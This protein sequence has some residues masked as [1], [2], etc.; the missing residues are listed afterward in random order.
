MSGISVDNLLLNDE[1]IK[2][3][4]N[5][6]RNNAFEY[7]GKLVSIGMIPKFKYEN[8]NAIKIPEYFFIIKPSKC[9]RIFISLNQVYCNSYIHF[10]LII[11]IWIYFNS[12]FEINI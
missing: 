10:I 8:K 7:K 3:D 4:S 6:F 9:L 12:E 2:S 11:V 1:V 5:V